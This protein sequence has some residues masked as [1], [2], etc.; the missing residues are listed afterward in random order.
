M[1]A[2][3]TAPAGQ[4]R[5]RG[6]TRDEAPEPGIRRRRRGRGFIYRDDCTGG[7]PTDRAR[8]RIRKLAIPPAW[9]DVWISRAPGAPLQATGRDSRGRKQYIY[10]ADFRAARAEEKYAR[11]LDFGRALRRMRARVAADLRRHGLPQRRILA[12]VVGLLDET[13][14]RVGN[15]AY[16]RENGTAGLT[17]L[18]QSDIEIGRSRVTLDFVGKGGKRQTV[19]LSD[20]RIARVLAQCSDLPGDGVFSWTNGEPEAHR[21]TSAQVNDYIREISGCE[22]TA[23][24]FRTWHGSVAAAAA[25]AE[26]PEPVS[27]RQASR[28]IAAAMKVVAGRL[29]NTPAVCR[30]SYVHPAVLDAFRSGLL[31][32]GWK[33]HRARWKRLRGDPAER[34]LLWL[35]AGLQD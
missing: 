28:A 17:T 32:H 16:A 14:L 26:V 34:L 13:A 19:S 7:T 11:M 2:R 6:S 9:E 15:D 1:N 33:V 22:C 27:E 5:A 25:L 3:G 20:P 24:D 12:A 29:G 31:Q 10:H 8:R 30:D 21:V 18:H 4:S 23:K 35:L